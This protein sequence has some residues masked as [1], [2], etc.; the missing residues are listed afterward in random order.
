MLSRELS[1]DFESFV[2]AR[3]APLLRI[4][5]LLTRNQQEAEDLLQTALLRTARRWQQARDQP[6]AYV[7]RV[8]INLAQDRGRA[9]R[10]ALERRALAQESSP[11][12][13]ADAGLAERDALL[14]ALRQL[15]ARQRAVVVLRF[16]DDM[17]VSEVAQCLGCSEGTVKST[18]SR[19]LVRLR[20]VLD[21]QH[22]QEGAPC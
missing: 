20:D 1:A 6:D 12:P 7:R 17:P 14:T 3:S 2:V 5:V 15:P 9:L 21:Y 8:L 13:A 19:A 16:W 18:T 10:R 4:A 11:T 22:R